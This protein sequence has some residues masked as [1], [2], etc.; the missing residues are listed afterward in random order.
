MMQEVVRGS[1]LDRT[2]IALDFFDASINRV[3]AWIIGTRATLLALLQ[4]LLE[5]S[6]RVRRLERDGDYTSRLALLE[7][8]KC[9]PYGAVWDYYCATNEVPVGAAWLDDVQRYERDVLSQR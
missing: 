4:A 8:L 7:A 9:M 3:A 5:P 1:Y 2:R 6:E